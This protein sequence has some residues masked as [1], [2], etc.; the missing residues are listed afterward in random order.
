MKELE[1]YKKY[2]FYIKRNLLDKSVCENINSQLNKIKTNM[3][4]VL[5]GFGLKI[6]LWIQIH[7]HQ[8]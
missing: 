4:S 3:M 7:F 8:T 2:G 5:K 6:H 1:T